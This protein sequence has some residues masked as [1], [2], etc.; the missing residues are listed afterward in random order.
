MSVT[1]GICVDQLLACMRNQSTVNNVAIKILTIVYLQ[2]I[3]VGCFTHAI[4]HVG[5]HFVMSNL[6]EF[7]TGW[8]NPFTHSPFGKN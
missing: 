8:I 4:D 5:E 7:M 3:D 6:S 2:L 1:Y